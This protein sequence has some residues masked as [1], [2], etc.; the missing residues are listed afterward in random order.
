MKSF[1]L[2]SGLALAAVVSAT[3]ALAQSDASDA[4][5]FVGPRA[6]IFGGWDRLG[7]RER[8]VDS[9]GATALI[10]KN[11]HDGWEAGGL[12]GYDMPIGSKLTAGILGSYAISTAKVCYP[13]GGGGSCVKANREIEGGA[14]LG[15]KLGNR[16][17]VYVKGAYVNGRYDFTYGDGVVYQRTSHNQN[18]WRAGAGAEFAVNKHVYVKAEY[19]YTRY[20]TYD[21][22]AQRYPI[23][24]AR[25]D[26]NQVLGGFGIRF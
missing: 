11:H 2:V 6:E 26:R 14:R 8:E 21:S 3:P 19:D 25:Y 17:L 24:Q 9:A 7:Q 18:G 16:S 15:Y 1:L 13:Y 5:S 20:N 4:P 22:A 10:S 12:V 23:V